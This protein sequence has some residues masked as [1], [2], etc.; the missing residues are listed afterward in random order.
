MSVNIK[1]TGGLRC[2]F[3]VKHKR[4]TLFYI[5]IASRDKGHNYLYDAWE[6]MLVH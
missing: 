4:K 3:I 1:V 5:I 2:E 6:R